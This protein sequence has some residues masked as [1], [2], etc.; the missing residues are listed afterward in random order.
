MNN[1]YQ[2]LLNKGFKKVKY[3]KQTEPNLWYKIEF[4]DVTEVEKMI[5]LLQEDKG[6]WEGSFDNL[7]ITIEIREDLS[8]AQYLIVE[9]SQDFDGKAF[10][11]LTIE[12]FEQLLDNLDDVIELV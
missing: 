3:T 2:K 1:L 11:E 9:H 4:T 10:D 5:E 12:E 8:Y 7:I 6:Y